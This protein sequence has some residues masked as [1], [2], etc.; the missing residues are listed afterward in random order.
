MLLSL[1]KLL[2]IVRGVLEGDELATAG[3]GNRLVECATRTSK[4]SNEAGRVDL[5]CRIVS[6]RPFA[7]PIAFHL[8]AEL[9]QRHG[10]EHRNPL[11]EHPER[12][13]DGALAA[14]APDPGVTFG[15]E[16]GDS[17]VV[18]HPRIKARQRR[19]DNPGVLRYR[20]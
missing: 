11:A 6:L 3:K 4:P 5:V 20:S 14:L 2:D 1:G 9:V 8:G 10:A 12:H 17:S 13:P 19:I 16:L 18:C 15:L 7:A